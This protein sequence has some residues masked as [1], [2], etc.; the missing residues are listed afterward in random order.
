VGTKVILRRTVK[1]HAQRDDA[2]IAAY[3]S[4]GILQIDNRI[5]IDTPEYSYEE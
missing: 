4:P 5:N 3:S 1:S 2:E